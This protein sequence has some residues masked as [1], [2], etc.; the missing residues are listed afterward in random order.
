ME[1]KINK[2]FPLHLAPAP[3]CKMPEFNTILCMQ[4][5]EYC[6]RCEH[7]TKIYD[8]VNFPETRRHRCKLQQ[9]IDI[10]DSPSDICEFEV[11]F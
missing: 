2:G 9:I 7:K 1:K 6:R 11:F 3:P 5:I 4:R 10:N 8:A